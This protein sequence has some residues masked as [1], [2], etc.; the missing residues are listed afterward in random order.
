MNTDEQRPYLPLITTS[1]LR[2]A[3]REFCLTERIYEGPTA[4][5]WLLSKTLLAPHRALLAYLYSYFLDHRCDV[6]SAHLRGS[7]IAKRLQLDGLTSDR[8]A[9]V[10]HAQNGS[11]SFSMVV[12]IDPELVWNTSQTKP[13][14]W[15]INHVDMLELRVVENLAHPNANCRA[16]F[17][18]HLVVLAQAATKE[19]SP[20]HPTQVQPVLQTVLA[21]YPELANSE[22][23]QVARSTDE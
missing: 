5:A 1:E 2:T 22:L 23:F 3:V 6:P 21:T 8:C 12:S 11:Y 20:P 13:T 10:L 19:S 14:H 15:T 17:P 9:A 16:H 4:N 18:P 7:H